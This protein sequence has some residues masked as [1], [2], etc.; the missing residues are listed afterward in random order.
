[1]NFTTGG[2]GIKFDTKNALRDIGGIKGFNL[3]A[4]GFKIELAP[5]LELV[6]TKIVVEGGIRIEGLDNVYGQ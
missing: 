1:M 6:P 3:D 5:E 2:L 4:I